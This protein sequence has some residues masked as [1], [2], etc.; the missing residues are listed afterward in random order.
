MVRLIKTRNDLTKYTKNY[1]LG[2]VPT[3]G[4]L[5]EGALV[6]CKRSLEKSLRSDCNY[7]R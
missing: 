6:T 1:D 3:M 2:L 7:F 4:N 5:H